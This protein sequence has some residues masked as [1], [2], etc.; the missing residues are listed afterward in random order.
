MKGLI[1]SL[2]EIEYGSLASSAVL[3][4]NFQF[5]QDKITELSELITSET[6]SF[7]SSVA[8]LNNSVNQLLS[9]KESFIPIGTIIAS[10]APEIPSGYLLCDG[11]EIKIEEYQDLYNVIGTTYGQSDSTSFCIPDLTARTVFGV[12][13]GNDL[14]K[15]LEAG[16]PNITGSISVTNL[17][18]SSNDSSGSFTNTYVK[19]TNNAGDGGTRAQ[20]YKFD[21]DASRSSKIYGKSSAVQPASVVTNFLIKY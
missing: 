4:N 13:E 21:F 3:N 12:S 5:L 16:L 14:G 11:S 9:Y 8:T 7:S 10:Q 15:Y 6:S 18:P 17:W 2:T 19:G 1:M 20:C